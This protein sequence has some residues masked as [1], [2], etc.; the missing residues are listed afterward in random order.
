MNLAIGGQLRLHV[1]LDDRSIRPAILHDAM[2]VPDRLLDGDIRLGLGNLSRGLELYNLR[3]H[4]LGHPSD[5]LLARG[6]RQDR[7]GERLRQVILLDLQRLHR[8]KEV[9]GEVLVQVQSHILCNFLLLIEELVRCKLRRHLGDHMHACELENALV[10]AIL[11]LVC[12]EKVAYSFWHEPVLEG[13]A[14]DQRQAIRCPAV[15]QVS[16]DLVVL[17]C[18]NSLGIPHVGGERANEVNAWCCNHFVADCL[19]K[20]VVLQSDFRRL[21][22]LHGQEQHENSEC[23]QSRATKF[24][25]RHRS[26]PKS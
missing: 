22:Q 4:G 7:R 8:R 14:Q 24:Q 26:R 2:L 13:Q 9:L 10:V 15:Q 17:Q 5:V 19:Q 21:Q 16:V 20:P 3:R 25:G 11:V 6:S 23:S 18:L 12:E 1:S